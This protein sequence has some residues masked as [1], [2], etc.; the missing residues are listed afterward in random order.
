VCVFLL[1]LRTTGCCVAWENLVYV[2]PCGRPPGMH[3][4]YRIDTVNS[5]DDGAHGCPKHVESRNKHT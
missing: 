5:P 4:R 2:T 3:A 1:V